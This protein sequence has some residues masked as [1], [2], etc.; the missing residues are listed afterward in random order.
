MTA[1]VDAGTLPK[2][3][4]WD[5]WDETES[6]GDFRVSFRRPTARAP[7]SQGFRPRVLSMSC[8][9]SDRRNAILRLSLNFNND[10]SCL[11]WWAH[12]DSNLGPAD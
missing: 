2:Q 5:N 7:S 10:G 4:R 3:I 12:K 8:Q 6:L 9:P 11:R 1:L